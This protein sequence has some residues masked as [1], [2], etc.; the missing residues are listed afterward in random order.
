MGLSFCAGPVER[1]FQP[2]LR[3]FWRS[4][5]NASPGLKAWAIF[6]F[7][8]GIWPGL[9]PCAVPIGKHC[10]LDF[11]LPDFDND[12]VARVVIEHLT[13]VFQGPKG[14]AVRAV[15]DVNLTI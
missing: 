6:G 3:D 10:E 1:R 12:C 7:P 14:E 13:K 4:H 5:F 9:G 15:E 2:S 11:D 8:F